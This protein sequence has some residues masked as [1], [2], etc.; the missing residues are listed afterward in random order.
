M[1]EAEFNEE[2]ERRTATETDR[3]LRMALAA[4]FM[5]TLV[6]QPQAE[7]RGQ[8]IRAVAKVIEL[9]TGADP[10]PE[11]ETAARHWLN[12]GEWPAEL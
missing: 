1:T 11:F 12:Y 6:R 2:L 10:L 4:L 9:R 5:T 8:A 3:N 7:F